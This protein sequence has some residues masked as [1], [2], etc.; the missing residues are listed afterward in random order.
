MIFTSLRLFSIFLYYFQIYTIPQYLLD[1]IY[2]LAEVECDFSQTRVQYKNLT[3]WG[4]CS[5]DQ[6]TFSGWIDHLEASNG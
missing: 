1:V 5:L 4:S 3:F 2:T 6:L